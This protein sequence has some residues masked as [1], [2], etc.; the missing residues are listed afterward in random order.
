M[1]KKYLTTGMIVLFLTVWMTGYSEAAMLT[2]NS[3]SPSDNTSTRDSW[4][5]AIGITSP[6]YV[7][8][9]ETGFTQDQNVSGVTGLFPGG[10]VITDTYSSGSA[11]I[12]GLSS[13]FGGSDP[14]GD[15]S[16]AHNEEQYLELSFSN[17]VNYIAFQ[18]ID[19][20]G[21]VVIVTFV[22]GDTDSIT[23]DRARTGPA[24]FFGIYNND[25]PLISLVQLDASGDGEWGIDTIEYGSQVPIPGAVW[26]F[27]SGIACFAG[28]RTRRK[29]IIAKKQGQ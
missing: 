23:L 20:Y 2:F 11:M 29:K 1:K 9:F 28:I 6:Q 12:S 13:D 4:L 3:T 26:L 18:D 8:D 16:L 14:V 15:F 10:L 5:T 22:G 21:A 19:H 17:P 7:V 27:G 25:M 24:E